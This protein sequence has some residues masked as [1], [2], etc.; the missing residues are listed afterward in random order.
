[1]RNEK[2]VLIGAGNLAV[3]LGKALFRGGF[4]ISQVYSR[5]SESAENLADILNAEAITNIEK[6]D[7]SAQFFIFAVNDSALPEL[8]RKIGHADEHVL[9]HTSGSVPLDVFKDFAK[10]YGVI[11]PLQT[12]SKFRNISF[13]EVPVFLEANTRETLTRLMGLVK[14][15]SLKVNFADSSQRQ[16][17]HLSAVFMNNFVNHF[18]TLGVNVSK[19]LGCHFGFDVF[20]PLILETAQKVLDSGNPSICQTGPAVRGNTEIMKKHLSLLEKNPEIQNLYTFVS[21]NISKYYNIGGL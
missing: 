9:I 19:D 5:T 21:E 15:I 1:M 10:N 17:L 18:Y 20:K 14:D 11:Y 8:L 7:K 13:L 2:I 12:F 6:I 16:V 3:H 4:N